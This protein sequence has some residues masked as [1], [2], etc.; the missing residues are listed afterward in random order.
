[1]MIAFSQPVDTA[2]VGPEPALVDAHYH[3]AA[4]AEAA[5]EP[6]EDGSFPPGR[7]SGRGRELRCSSR[8]FRIGVF[9]CDRL[10]QALI[11]G[12]VGL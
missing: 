3:E 6:A 9:G 7:R 4:F 10:R 11:L 1:M 8:F 12:G 2:C 5:R